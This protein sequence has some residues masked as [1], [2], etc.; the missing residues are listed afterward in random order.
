MS[1]GVD[2]SV[3][4]AMMRDDQTEV[5]GMTMQLY[6]VNDGNSC[7][8][9]RKTCCAGVD[10]YDAK[11]AAS[12]LNIAHYVLNYESRFKE[13][14]I[15]EFADSYLRGETPI[16][17]I[18]C[19]QEVK[20]KDLLTM[21][22]ELGAEKLAT[23]H[24]VRKVNG[25]DGAELHKAI[26]EKKDQSYFLFTTGQEQLEFLEF[27]LGGFTKDHTRKLAA[28]YG[29][30]IADKPDSQDICFVP[31]GNYKRVIERLRPESMQEGDILDVEG[32]LIGRHKGIINYTVG[33]RKGLGMAKSEPYY[34]ISIDPARNS[35]TVG[36]EKHLYKTDFY[37]KDTNW[38][39]EEKA[40][41]STP[42]VRVRSSQ[43]EVKA[44]VSL[45]KDGV[46]KVQLLEP[47]KLITPGQ[48]CVFYD[49][50]RVLGGGWIMHE[51]EV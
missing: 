17:C 34:V 10:I 41:G 7:S 44:K 28:E 11:T 3:V 37:I 12:H 13:A 42:S 9:K 20:F 46:Y 31:D 2:S 40:L 4:A 19:N 1:G 49:G 16:P 36:P 30:A 43:A 15:D 47:S 29:L 26:D 38:L 32:N 27:P 14:V 5:I 48:A 33:Q 22:R 18:R 51:S 8:T 39:A 6:D 25:P 45:H 23:G 50:T 35:I 24:Y 21:A